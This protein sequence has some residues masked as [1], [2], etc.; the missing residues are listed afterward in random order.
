[1]PMLP[2]LRSV[3]GLC[4]LPVATFAI[5]P[6]SLPSPGELTQPRE[7]LENAFG[8]PSDQPHLQ[9]LQYGNSGHLNV[10]LSYVDRPLQIG[11]KNFTH[12]LG[13]H[14]P[15]N[16][17]L[18][19]TQP[20]T[21][22]H[23]HVGFD[24]NPKT[25]ERV[26]SRLIFSVEANGREIW[27]SPALGVND[28]AMPV[29]LP[30][31]G[32]T[33]LNFR[34][35]TDGADNRNAHGD[36]ADAQLVYPD[37]RSV[38]L[39]DFASHSYLIQKLPLSFTLDGRPSRD[40][41]GTWEKTATSTTEPDRIRH[42]LRWRKPDG[43]FEVR[44]ELIEFPGYP[45]VE[46]Q[47]H[48]KNTGPA[49][50]P[51]LEKVLPLDAVINRHRQLSK[52]S[53]GEVF[54]SVLAA[55][56]SANTNTDFAP[57]TYPIRRGLS[58][59]LGS[60]TGRSSDPYLPFWN[61]D[62]GGYGFMTALGWSGDWQA[63]IR[64]L[65]SMSTGMQAGMAHLRLYLKPGEEI[66]SPSVCLVFWE[67]DPLRGSNHLRRFLRERIAP[68][69]AGDQPPVISAMAGGSSA[70]ETVNERN[71]LDYIRKIAGTGAQ[72]YWLD[73]GWYHG[74]AGADWSAG[75][76][77]WF[78]SQTKFPRGLRPLGDEAHRHGLKFLLWYDPELVEPGTVIA[79]QHPEW[80]L[81]RENTDG[82][83]LFN[84][85]DPAACA[86]LT[87]LVGKGL[88]DW[89][90]DIYRNDF[91]LDPRDFWRRA[92][93]PDRT[94]I[95]EL[96]YIEGLYKFWDGLRA[97]KPG[98]L[99][100]NCASGGRRIDYEL[101]KRSVPLWRSDYEC[102]PHADLYE[103]SQNQLYGLSY[104]LPYHGTGQAM[105]FN[106]YQDR[107]LV[108]SS[109][110]LS[111]GAATPDSLAEVPHDR[112]KQ[113]WDDVHAYSPLLAY[114]FYPLTDYS[115]TDRAWMALQYDKPETG[116][117]C[118]VVFRRRESPYTAS[119]ISLR[120]IDPQAAY[121]LTFL[122][123]GEQRDVSGAELGRLS[124]R[125]EKGGS[126]VIKYQKRSSRLTP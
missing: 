27:A 109:T 106:R 1:M 18:A 49:N 60:A 38:P 14:A 120:A 29:D 15:S 40:F 113:V 126:A 103:S 111:I 102:D 21:R 87:D 99:I 119:E 9:I 23:A 3:V 39:G 25:L 79:V 34:V 33:R 22:F 73:A 108:S 77:N 26:G 98:L 123:T 13:V 88:R 44:C 82:Y 72:V 59:T 86:Y 55:N 32:A 8:L 121:R 51:I 91:N 89:D 56:G 28:P 115:G 71:Q 118:L 68:T 92:D 54:A 63:D 53:D 36:W 35:R 20:P 125:L 81:H 66:S 70:L 58:T 80:L 110:V 100:D 93:P 67:G 48:F 94:G 10:D 104:F 2:A 19:L 101:T 74:P 31:G 12:G 122:N 64:R 116:E 69:W 45:A 41:L 57:L 5:T 83:A 96:R 117:G 84:L 61:F 78:P 62:Y 65:N 76:G 105:T 97:A 16:L 17:Q 114:D 46:W 90:V 50:S 47:L 30:L 42:H 4:V 11:E 124:L 107:S 6:P 95:T 85:G 24:R 43:T 75:R 37:G 112:V 7:L 52:N